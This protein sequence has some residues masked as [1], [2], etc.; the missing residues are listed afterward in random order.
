MR[1]PCA[2]MCIATEEEVSV[3]TLATYSHMRSTGNA[4]PPLVT[5]DCWWCLSQYTRTNNLTPT[6]ALY[7]QM[8]CTL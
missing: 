7:I 8:Y 3:S 1:K 4:E 5:V 6:N 2:P